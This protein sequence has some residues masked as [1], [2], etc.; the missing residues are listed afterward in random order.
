MTEHQLPTHTRWFTVATFRRGLGMTTRAPQ[1]PDL[2]S[3]GSQQN[4]KTG[5]HSAKA[6]SRRPRSGPFRHGGRI[7]DRRLVA[8]RTRLTTG[9]AEFDSGQYT[10]WPS[11]TKHG[12]FEWKGN[13]KDA[14]NGDG[15]NVYMQVRIE[16]YDWNRYNGTQKKSVPLDYVNWSGNELY[17]Q[18][19]SLRVCRNGAPCT[20]TT[21][22]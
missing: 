18:D 6:G 20:R 16:G 11:G 22:R 21:A 13:L 19:A 9:G 2:T 3:Q 10:F 4:A 14:D 15:H 5:E 17:T 12:G 7:R 1:A 8:H